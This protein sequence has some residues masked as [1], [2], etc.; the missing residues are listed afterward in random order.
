VPVLGLNVNVGL[1]AMQNA[2]KIVMLD[3]AVNPKLIDEVVDNVEEF[4]IIT[5]GFAIL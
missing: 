3:V 2:A 1:P 4:T 5:L